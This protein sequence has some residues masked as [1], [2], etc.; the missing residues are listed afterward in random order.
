MSFRTTRRVEFA[1][2]DMAGIVHF[3]QFFQY[4]EAAEHEFLRARGL[5]VMMEWE[6]VSIS[7]PRVAAS[8]DFA[9]PAHFE[10]ELEIT[11]ALTR[12]GKKSLTYAIEFFLKGERIAHG[13]ISSVCCRVYPGEHRLE[14]IEIPA[15]I[16]SRLEVTSEGNP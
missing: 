1:D 3:A 8:C 12:L 14:S 11:V 6:G 2:T 4:M 16:R 15:G 7:F 9:K 13:Q 10:D 5:S